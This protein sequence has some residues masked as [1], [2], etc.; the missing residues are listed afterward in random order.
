[1]N[2]TDASR[3]LDDARR[4]AAAGDT[5]RAL[6]IASTA[7]SRAADPARRSAAAR[8]F[9]SL[10]A[11]IAFTAHHPRLEA[12]LLACLDDPAVEAQSLARVAAG[13]LL[14]KHPQ[15]PP[16]DALAADPLWLAF[17]TRCVNVLP[18]ME[19][20][21]ASLRTALAG[22][23]AVPAICALAVQIAASEYVLPT[24]AVAIG[25]RPR[26]DTVRNLLI[27]TLY[28]PLADL[29]PRF[30]R[31]F[32]ALRA[33][34]AA[35]LLLARAI[36]EPAEER[37]LAA[38]LPS[39]GGDHPSSAPVRAQYEASPYPRWQAPPQPA[40]T[41]LAA[42]IAALPGV[43]RTQ[44]PSA[45]LDVLV[46]GCGTGYEAI[47][48]ARTDPTL[49]IIALD[50]SRASL[51]Y[52]F[53][54]AAALGA[55][56]GFVQGDLLRLPDDRQFDLATSTGVLHH[57]D[58]PAEG[59]AALV[60]VLRPGGLLR[61]GLYSERAR[62]AVRAAHATIERHGFPDTPEGIRAFRAHVLA[63]PAGSPLAP[64]LTSDDFY[65]LSGCRDLCFHVREH[66][67]SLPQIGAMLADMGLRL[68]GIDASAEAHARFA[69]AFGS[70]A[71]RLDLT[72]WDRLEAA[73]PHLFAG[74]YQL[75][76]QRVS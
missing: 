5:G 28:E 36:A 11:G 29:A 26:D 64:L 41:D 65:S 20:R 44:L 16:P 71:D 42:L 34:P 59:L 76:A 57:L 10:V 61:I 27:A 58:Q 51:G 18:A 6:Q 17:L 68:A 8:C 67:F 19:A 3:L 52:A 55:P 69:A 43:D 15:G 40:R 53:R 45:P 73:H 72:R 38:A 56:V 31:A 24:T 70:A 54:M 4:A 7:L 39:M 37:R 33:E 35:A 48:L 21:L 66:R 14:L 23:D 75:W 9:A 22:S 32:D 74:M 1:M 25:A 60:R 62:S 12:D 63:Q 13:L 30:P 50:L 46:A 2:A 47:D 49:S